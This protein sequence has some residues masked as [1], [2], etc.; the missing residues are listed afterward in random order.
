MIFNFL[1]KTSYSNR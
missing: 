1:K